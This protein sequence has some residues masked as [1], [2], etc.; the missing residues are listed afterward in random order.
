MRRRVAIGILSALGCGCALTLTACGGG[1]GASNP[2]V[3]TPARGPGLFYSSLIREKAT[4]QY[5]LAWKSLH[6]SH[7][8]VAPHNT[9]V[10][11]ENR[12]PFPGRLLDV[13]VVRVQDEPVLI[14]GGSH[15]VPSKAVTVR[16]SVDSPGVDR[17]VVVTETYHA[18]AVDGRWTWI[19]TRDN[20][21]E[22]KA[23]HCPGFA[24]QTPKA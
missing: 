14:A 6:P 16:V 23:G 18:V 17:T 22:Y 11:C 7:Q 19:L 4:G 1:A 20:F 8:R 9:Y 5:D 15:T 24:P 12:T 13:S 10:E 2:A 3:S 21:A